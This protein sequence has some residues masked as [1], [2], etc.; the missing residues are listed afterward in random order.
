MLTVNVIQVGFRRLL[1][2]SEATLS[3]WQHLVWVENMV[4]VQS[5]FQRCHSLDHS[6][7]L[8]V[9]QE[10][11]FLL[12]N[13]VLC[14]DAAIDLAAVVHHEGFNHILGS[15]LQASVFITW[16]DNVQMKVSIADVSVS[17]WQDKLF[18]F[19]REL[20][21]VLDQLASVLHNLVVMAGWQA[22]IVL[23]SLQIT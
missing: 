17:I 13:A 20:L 23:K 15:L 11:W 6:S 12:A 8:G 3:C 9:V 5:L 14:R 22:D 4:W 1:L 10:S 18:F 21:R 16:Q 7:A 19:S 2:H